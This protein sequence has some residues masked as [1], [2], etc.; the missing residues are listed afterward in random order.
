[1]AIVADFDPNVDL[2]VQ[3]NTGGHADPAGFAAPWNALS[4]GAAELTDVANQFGEKY[5]A[6]RRQAEATNTVAQAT[7]ALAELS[8]KYSLMPDRAAA[9]AGY[10]ADA[11][12]L[13]QQTLSGID[14][15]L[16]SQEVSARFDEQALNL[17]IETGK[18]AFSLESSK[19]RGTLVTNLADYAQKAATAPN[20]GYRAIINDNAIG[21]ID[22][23]VAGGWLHPEE[24]E[25]MKLEYR[26]NTAAV[27]VKRDMNADP[28]MAAQKL[29]DPAEYPGLLPAQRETFQYRAEMRADRQANQ[30]IAAQAH[31][32]AM[33]ERNLRQTQATNEA[34]ILG[35]VIAGSAN[36]PTPGQMSDLAAHGLISASGLDTIYAAARRGADGQDSAPAAIDLYQKLGQGSLTADDIHAAVGHG[37][38]STRTALNLM[39]GLNAR[40]KSDTNA[41]ERGAFG[42]LK[43]ALSGD[44][45][46]K[47][48]FGAADHAPQV[49][50]WAQAQGEWT[51]RVTVGGEDPQAVLSDML[52]RYTSAQAAAPTWLPSPRFGAVTSSDDLNA[53]GGATYQALQAGKIDQATYDNQKTLLNQYKAFYDRQN[54]QR[55][56]T[57][58]KS[59]APTPPVKTPAEGG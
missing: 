43:T 37:E 52:P 48:M 38:L 14:S 33:A 8:H 6:A 41:I 19:Q 51:K 54:A 21:A 35:Q 58:P 23:S 1:M 25:Q 16:V 32:D 30:A 27:S 40:G 18:Q 2:P 44:A 49:A 36:A 50:G 17:G 11:A 39:E 15:P 12:A 45:I 53:V 9:M 29:S 4:Q 56:V 59:Q 26:S 24:G 7:G 20:D 42:Q 31:A 3:V 22:S 13:K 5:I 47:G 34:T 57:A 10:S 28:A 46:E 55:T